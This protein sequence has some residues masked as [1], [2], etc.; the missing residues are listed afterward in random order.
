MQRNPE[1][2]G[3][4]FSSDSENLRYLWN[5]FEFAFV[6]GTGLHDNLR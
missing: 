2:I 1:K 6:L 5:S 3:S 4:E